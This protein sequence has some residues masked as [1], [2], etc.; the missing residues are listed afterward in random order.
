MFPVQYH[1]FM[2]DKFAI[3]QL[4]E[5][6][7]MERVSERTLIENIVLLLGLWVILNITITVY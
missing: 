6:L 5:Q 2:H 3:T 4:Y 7:R 1:C